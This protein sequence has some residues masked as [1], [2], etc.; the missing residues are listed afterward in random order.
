MSHTTTQ[1]RA[2]YLRYSPNQRI[3]VLLGVML[4][5]ILVAVDATIINVAIPAMRGNLGVT[6][7]QITWVSVGYML[8]NVVFLP[9][10]GWLEA[11]L[12]RRLLLVYSVITFTAASFLCGTA[13]SLELLVLYRVLQG[14]GGAIIMSSGM[15][16][17]LEVFP[18]K[19]AGVVSAIAGIGVMV[20]PAVGPILGGWLV[21]SYSWPW[22][23][24]INVV[25]GVLS[26]LVL[27]FKMKNPQAST[28]VDRTA[29]LLG[30]LWLVMGVGCFQ[31]LLGKGERLG[32]LDST[33]IR[34]LAV[35]SIFGVA[36]LIHRSLTTRHP[37]INLRLL[38]NRVLAA[39]CACSFMAGVGIFSMLFVLPVFLQN[40]RQYSA[41]QSGTIMLTF[42]ICS[43]AAMVVSGGLVNR[44][45][46]RLL[47]ALGAVSCAL[48]LYA[49]SNVT[50]L[51]GPE[52]L[53]WPQVLL[54]AGIGLLFVPLMTASLAG[55][56][57]TDLG[58]GSGLWNMA[59][60]LGGTIGIALISTVL[61]KRMVFH[62]TMLAESVNV[63]SPETV[64]RFTMLQQFFAS[65]GSALAVARERALA[66][67][68]QTIVGQ[69][70]IM[71]Y[72][73]LFLLVALAFAL[74]LPLVF[75]LRDP[76]PGEE[77]AAVHFE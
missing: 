4:G 47:V 48:A 53:F 36:L 30:I 24:Y 22:I 38:K 21:D 50:Y 54:G 76:K 28:G 39:G 51:S 42:A 12:G 43:A 67:L 65:K 8:A 63:Y 75:L 37:A 26:A 56:T 5:L 25:P 32:W 20:G 6:M 69:A 14:M 13:S 66:A 11:R 10:T 62:H 9:L 49:M 45:P 35:L 18:P 44:V 40:L 2:E 57:G 68:D 64:S 52:H 33:F 16:A 27:C 41:Q 61:T 58:E 74:I 60:Q 19:K 70:A 7:D 17:M 3:A 73:D 23:F 29:D 1:P 77:R 31:I 59:R 15:A 34:W 71:S 72:N 55:L 46:A